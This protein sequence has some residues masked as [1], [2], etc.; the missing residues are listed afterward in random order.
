MQFLNGSSP[1]ALD[2]LTYLTC[3]QNFDLDLLTL[4]L[5]PYCALHVKAALPQVCLN[6]YC[7]LDCCTGPGQSSA[8][9]LTVSEKDTQTLGMLHAQDTCDH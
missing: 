5:E 9:N 2:V 4:N 6:C 7:C 1:G 8:K 3:Y